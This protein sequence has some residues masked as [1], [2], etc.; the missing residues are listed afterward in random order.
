[1]KMRRAT[2]NFLGTVAMPLSLLRGMPDDQ[3]TAPGVYN[4][5]QKIKKGSCLP[6][7]AGS[8]TGEYTDLY[9]LRLL[10]YHDFSCFP[11]FDLCAGGQTLIHFSE[12]LPGRQDTN[13]L[14]AELALARAS[15][16][17]I[18]NLADS[19]PASCGLY[20]P[21]ALETL[22]NADTERYV[23]DPR[24]LL[25]ARKALAERF[26]GSPA[27]F[28]LSASTSETY[29][30]LFKLLCDPGDT[31]LVPKPGYPLFDYLAGLEAVRAEPYHL[32]Y[33]HPGPWRIDLDQ[34]REKAVAT[35][36][37]AV[38]LINPNNPT[39]SYVSQDEREAI[40]QLCEHTAMAIIADEVFLPYRLEE[41]GQ[42]ESFGGECRCLVF[43]L[44]GLSKLLGLPQY[45]LGWMRLSGPQ[46][47]LA[48]ASRRL[49]IIADTY[50]S[51]GAPVMN[52]LPSLLPK[53][54]TFI[55]ELRLRLKANLDHARRI[56]GSGNS[57][58]RVLRCDGGWTALVEY[59]RILP[60]EELALS[61][62]QD[63]GLYVHPGYFFDT[64]RDGY[65]AISLI[66]EEELF[67]EGLSLLRL[68]LDRMLV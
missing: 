62:L 68:F 56:L 59:P 55:Y 13:S 1:M 52:A 22:V 20:V 49:E 16:R 63:L 54:D 48:E 60:D 42:P 8:S 33:H 23:P 5:S 58:Y 9:S 10:D 28:F 66:L 4:T 6:S 21:G 36:A 34:L 26:G 12:R 61:L 39:G 46:E 41:A 45:K 2:E 32:E 7:M 30:W 51:V 19:N 64:P 50:L 67:S 18:I 17:R 43:A 38:V 57:P 25:V 14:G 11:G 35:K 44:D 37:K 53:A 27:E 24:G 40:L 31:V 3:A 15:G 29:S 65:L 47:V